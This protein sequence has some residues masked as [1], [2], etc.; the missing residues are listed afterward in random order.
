VAR[1]R[2]PW[3]SVRSLESG[4]YQA[5]YLD[6]DTLRM[7]P[8]PQTFA[9]KRGA[10][11]WLAAKRTDLDTGTSV[12]DKAGNRPLR[13]WWPGY[14]RSTQSRKP[15][16]RA[17]YETAWRL[18]IEPRFGSMPVRR[19]KPSHVDDWVAD[20]IEQG[21]SVS[22]ITESLGVLKRVLDRVAR[23]WVIATNPCSLR[24]ASLPKRSQ[25]ERPVL[26]PAEVEKLAQ[27]MSK[28]SDRVLVRLLAFGGLRINECF[29]LQWSDVDLERK[30][31]TVR[32]SV[33]DV[34]GRL[35]VGPTKTY[36]TRTITLPE[37]L[38]AQ[39]HALRNSQPRVAL[40]FPS[41]RGGYRRYGNWR[42]DAWNPACETSGVGARP[43][44]LRATCASLLID[45][46]ASPKDVQAHLG[47]E[48]VETTMRW[49]ARVRPGRSEDLAARLNTLIAEVA[50]VS[51]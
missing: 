34:N 13:E 5:R 6:P 32:R 10:D 4:R 19:I 9:T 31:L 1:S 38:A 25:M 36:A 49:Y 44:D 47:H 51:E 22:K 35:I 23:D 2:R 8:A 30:M 41:R 11:R 15:Q 16:T 14:W 27:A 28:E 3:G 50:Y 40:V 48:S 17:G 46:G 29:A 42:R 33:G 26:S 12:D 24:A 45:A 18:R 43:H 20:M 21:L 37:A 39:L 7:T